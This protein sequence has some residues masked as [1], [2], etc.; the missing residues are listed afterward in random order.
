MPTP[1]P[2]IPFPTST[3]PGGLPIEGAGRLINC[4]AEP[5]LDG[6]TVR[7]RQPGLATFATTAQTGYRG[8]LLVN[9]NLFV[10]FNGR[11]RKIDSAGVDTDIGALAG[12]KK[13]I[14]ARNN[15][16]PTPQVAIVTEN[17]AFQ[18]DASGTAPI[19]WA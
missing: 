2:K 8:S 4:S 1:P 7:H 9:N 13:V 18:T 3:A 10:A 19:T 16:A 14:M 17:G 15:R 5:L 11:L 12:T 6:R